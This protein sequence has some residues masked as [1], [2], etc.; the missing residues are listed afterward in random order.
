MADCKVGSRCTESNVSGLREGRTPP[1]AA[2]TYDAFPVLRHPI[3]RR[4]HL[5][6]MYTI[7]SINKWI[8]QFEKPMPTSPCEKA[9]NILENKGSRSSTS[10]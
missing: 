7:A 5:A 8:Q 2:N 9:F 3:V 6:Y 1:K 4:I 10:N